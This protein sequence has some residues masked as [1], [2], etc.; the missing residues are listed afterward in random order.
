MCLWLQK[1]WRCTRGVNY[2][3]FP[4][5]IQWSLDYLENSA[6][7]TLSLTKQLFC[8]VTRRTSAFSSTF[9]GTVSIFNRE[10]VTFLHWSVASRGN[11]CKYTAFVHTVHSKNPWKIWSDSNFCSEFP[12]FGAMQ[13]KKTKNMEGTRKAVEMENE[14]GNLGVKLSKSGGKEKKLRNSILWSA[15]IHKTMQ[16]SYKHCWIK[17]GIFQ[18]T[19]QTI[20]IQPPNKLGLS[21]Y[22]QNIRNQNS[23]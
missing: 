4:C 21:V 16:N 20:S 2:I 23:I 17:K 10:I 7:S 13:A 1:R 18:T 19:K 14:R 8:A 15:S 12:C 22:F 11:V 6:I 9:L 5:K 3:P